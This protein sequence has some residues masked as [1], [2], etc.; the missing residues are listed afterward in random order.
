MTD[1]TRTALTRLTAAP[2]DFCRQQGV[3]YHDFDR[4]DVNEHGDT[5]LHRLLATHTSIDQL[6]AFL[7]HHLFRNDS[8]RTLASHSIIPCIQHANVHGINALHIAVFRNSYHVKEI[9][10]R[11]LQVDASLAHV[12]MAGN[13]YPLHICLAYSLTIEMPVID[14][15]LNANKMAASSRN[16]DGR[17]ALDLLTHNVQRFRWAQS[18]TPVLECSEQ[19]DYTYMTIISP[20]QY[21]QIS[22]KI[23][24]CM[25]QHVTWH[26]VAREAPVLLLLILLQQHSRVPGFYTR[27]E[28]GRYPLLHARSCQSAELLLRHAGSATNIPDDTGRWPL[29]Q[30]PQSLALALDAP[31]ALGCMDPRTGCFPYQLAAAESGDIET[32]YTLLRMNPSVIGRYHT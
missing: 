3:Y 18:K 29:H 8:S 9:I 4:Q 30:C 12:P 23:L 27:D 2:N 21:M 25:G 16:A 31:E 24:Q 32:I 22:I 19:Q 28:S 7:Q 6:D 13:M 1:A 5:A 11:L 10:Q 20:F 14:M 17:S 15:L 26:L